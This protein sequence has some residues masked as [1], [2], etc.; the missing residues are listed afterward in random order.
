M[1]IIENR[2]KNLFYIL[3]EKAKLV[4]P[5]DIIA[6]IPKPLE[7]ELQK[8]KVWKKKITRKVRV[9]VVFLHQ[10]LKDIKT[11]KPR[12]IFHCYYE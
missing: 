4:K 5:D 11:R 3:S 2:G 10:K 6:T 12:A 1:F 9:S 8:V 7:A